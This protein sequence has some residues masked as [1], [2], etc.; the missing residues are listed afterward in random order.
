[1]DKPFTF[2]DWLKEITFKKSPWESFSEDQILAFNAFMIHRYLSMNQDYIEL[3]NIVQKIPSSNKKQ[4]YLTYKN[5][6]P[7]KYIH[8]KYIGKNKKSENGDL[9]EI[10]SNYYEI[11][12]REA[13]DYIELLSKSDLINILESIG[14]EEKE[15]KKLINK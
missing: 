3:V 12:K 1:M 7:K 5:L 6:I 2:F 9:I 14:T 13:I 11:S 10:I 4:I 8:L 15:I